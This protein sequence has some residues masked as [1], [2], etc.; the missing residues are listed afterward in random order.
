VAAS[1]RDKISQFMVTSSGAL[2][3]LKPANVPG[4]QSPY[5]IAVNPQATSVY[6]VDVGPSLRPANKISQYTINT[7][8]GR[9]TP[10]SPATV[11][12]GRAPESI[13]IAPNGTS[14][15]VGDHDTV[16][17][18]TINPSTGALTPKSPLTVAALATTAAIAVS[19]NGRYA[20]VATCGGC[21]YRRRK[22]SSGVTA[23]PRISD[24]GSVK[25]SYL[26]EYRI[27]PSTGAL[28]ANPVASVPTGNGANWIAIAPNDRSAYVASG[29][30]GGTVWQY[31]INPSTGK[32]TPKRPEAVTTG[33]ATHNIVIAPNG[34]NAY[35]IGAF[36]SN[37]AQYRINPSTGSLAS[38]P[39][40]TAPTV[41]DPEALAIAA[42]GKNAYVTSGDDPTVAQYTINPATGT[43]TPM[44]PATVKT[45][46]GAFG[47][48]VAP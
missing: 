4:G 24:A 7:V 21:K 5:G 12:T 31:T 42:N 26:L 2:R 39:V 45:A 9:L 30:G 11:A 17:Q 25:P 10:K 46:S 23:G 15:Y 16:S 32:V 44:T 35:V 13:A 1:K 14:A 41:L 19:F 36:D 40:S 8:T 22:S 48:T 3:S 20:Y 34:K 6:A 18:Y 43:I 38:R 28:S 37:V 33:G 29:T 47:V 27:N